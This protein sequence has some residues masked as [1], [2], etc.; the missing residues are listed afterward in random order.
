MLGIRIF[1]GGQPLPAAVGQLEKT[2]PADRTYVLYAGREV[3]GW[4]QILK[5]ETGQY[6]L[7]YVQIVPRYRGKG[8]GRELVCFALYEHPAR[9]IYCLTIIPEFFRKLGLFTR[10]DY[11]SFVDH[12]DPECRLCEPAKCAALLFAKPADLVRYG[13]EQ[14][15]LQKYEQ[16]IIS[17]RN[18]MGS[19]FSAANEKTW[20]Y[21]ENI[22]FL[23]IDDYLF[24][25]AYPFAAE[26]F[27]IICPYR[28]IPDTA[29]DKYF[30]RLR[31][32]GIR[33]LAYVNA[34]ACRLLHKYSGAGGLKF[35]EDR[36]NFDYLY[37]TGDFA[38][39]A[40]ARYA[41]KRNRLKKF[42]RNNSG[43]EIIQY[44]P[45]LKEKFFNFA[46]TR[47][48]TMGVD[49]ISEEVLR[50][51]LEQNLYQ[52]FMVKAG[53]VEI[54]ILL[55]SE[56][57]PRTIIVHFELMDAAYDG[58]AQFMNNYLGKLLAGKYTF[59]NRE[60]DLGLAGLRRSKQS[61][62]PYRLIKKYSVD[63]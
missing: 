33:R 29:L 17:G 14:K 50:L 53:R 30:A 54:G 19:E 45:E 58:A 23:E 61:Y 7:A 25:T 36:A 52:G 47:F 2:V 6:E 21:A 48:T 59:I 12:S 39:Y 13:S 63:F 35:Q 41:D 57:N 4:A 1:Y 8:Y 26:P 40:G 3:A 55:Y 27:G 42:L 60:Q 46:Q 32:L 51:G 62:N 28:S 43:G 16:E 56:L 31:E 44:R 18:F 24:L 38:A 11:P 9:Q 49:V 34:A 15:L 5:H 20:T 37:K 22:Y 10:A